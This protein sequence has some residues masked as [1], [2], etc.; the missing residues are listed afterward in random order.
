MASWVGWSRRKAGALGGCLSGVDPTRYVCSH[1][2]GLVQR[3]QLAVY[4]PMLGAWVFVDV[5][6]SRSPAEREGLAEYL[7]E[8]QDNLK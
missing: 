4:L 7:R 2:A 3:Q 6:E 1:G 5:I 8:G